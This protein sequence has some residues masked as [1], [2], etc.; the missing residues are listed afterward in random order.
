M[1]YLVAVDSGHGM[2]TAG[3]RTPPIP[4][5]WFGKKKGESIHE[6]EFNKPTAE[7]LIK[8]LN[9][10]GFNTIN[11]SPGITD[12]PLTNRWRAANTAKADIFVSKHYNAST[13]KWGSANGIETIISQ[14]AG[15]GSKRLAKSVQ[16][17]LVKAHKRNDRGVKTDIL[18]SCINI[19]VLHNTIMPAILTESGFMD[20]LTEAKSMLDMNFQ[21]ADAEATCRGICNFFGITYIEDFPEPKRTVTRT[22]SKEDIKWLQNKLNK[23]LHGE[24]YIPL[25]VDGI[26]DTKTR[27][28]VLMLWESR[29]WKQ[30]GKEDGWSVSGGTIKALSKF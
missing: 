30:D 6:K 16:E 17:E 18:Q 21:K 19:A 24:T 3:K 2:E 15:T 29:G 26:Y 28:A 25:T 7:Y 12:V 13:G 11:V 23:A 20:N 22:S 10:C 27:I 4:E 1:P 8:A 5:D 14:Y 9:R